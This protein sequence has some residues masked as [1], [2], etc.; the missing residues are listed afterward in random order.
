VLDGKNHPR[1]QKGGGGADGKYKG[2]DIGTLS[3]SGDR[4]RL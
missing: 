2:L 4:E 3:F 1:D